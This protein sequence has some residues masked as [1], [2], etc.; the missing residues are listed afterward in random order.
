MCSCHLRAWYRFLWTSES[1]ILNLKP[2][3]H[4]SLIMKMKIA[5]LTEQSITLASQILSQLLWFPTQEE[6]SQFLSED[7]VARSIFF[8][9]FKR[10]QLPSKK[11]P[12]PSPRGS[13]YPTSNISKSWG[14]FTPL[15]CSTEVKSHLLL[16]LKYSSNLNTATQISTC[17]YFLPRWALL[18]VFEVAQEKS[19][20]SRTKKNN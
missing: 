17:I 16:T 11:E 20:Q 19:K 12:D 3:Y 7:L 6:L 14:H 10:L 9:K 8:P 1:S 2:S 13:T 15:H 5:V 4:E 18:R